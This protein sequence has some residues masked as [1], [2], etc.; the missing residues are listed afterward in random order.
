M[1]EQLPTIG[2]AQT[3]LLAQQALGGKQGI[4]V[5]NSKLPLLLNH[6]ASLMEDQGRLAESEQLFR[7]ALQI[8]FLS[9]KKDG[10]PPG[11]EA[12]LVKGY[13]ALLGKMGNNP[14]KIEMEIRKLKTDAGVEK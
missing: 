12:E 9:Q 1:Y 6:L 14:E 10:K 5:G 3:Q 8:I 7:R 2:Q 4:G 11:I 13:S